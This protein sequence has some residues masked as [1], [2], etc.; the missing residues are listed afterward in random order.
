[1]DKLFNWWW[2]GILE[3]NWGGRVIMILFVGIYLYLLIANGKELRKKSPVLLPAL[4]LGLILLII[5][6][7]YVVF[8]VEKLLYLVI[9]LFTI[10][11]FIMSL[12]AGGPR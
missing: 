3:L 10:F 7:K 11:D 6:G 9:V 2:E 12:L 4:V 8:L 5:F 1:M